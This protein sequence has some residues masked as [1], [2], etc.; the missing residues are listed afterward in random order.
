MENI[1]LE[2]NLIGIYLDGP[3][4][5]HG[6]RQSHPGSSPLRMEGA[7][8]GSFDLDTA[9]SRIV[10]NELEADATAYFGQQ[11]PYHVASNHFHGLRFAVH[12]MYTNDSEV[13]DNISAGNDVG[14][15]LMYSD[16]LAV[17]GNA[18]VAIATGFC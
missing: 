11:P 1:L 7:G 17:H 16:R 18:S 12:F 8:A 14:F 2:D 5:C 10:D 4:G 9:G 3:H 13:A 6:A 15:V